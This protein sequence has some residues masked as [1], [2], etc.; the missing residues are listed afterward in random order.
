[1]DRIREIFSRLPY[2]LFSIITTLLIL[3]LT[4]MPDPLG[5]DAPTLF[6]GADK[7]VHAIMFGFLSVMLLLDY[8]RK[9]GWRETGS[10]VMLIAAF[11]SSALGILIEFIQRWMAMGRGFDPGDM[12]ADVAGV[13]ICVFL[14]S[15]LQRHWL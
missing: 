15:R 5:D 8:Q 2:W 3:W 9:H 10:G 4:L 11:I 12:V 7:V 14:W 6:P 1:M 13:V